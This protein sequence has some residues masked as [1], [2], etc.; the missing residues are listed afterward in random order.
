MNEPKDTS[1]GEGL[2][3]LA[4]LQTYLGA[5]LVLTPLLLWW[6]DT[7]DDVRPSISAY[8]DVGEPWAFYVPLT[9]GAMLFLVNGLIKK[10]HA[11][12]TGLGLALFGVILFDHKSLELPHE[13][14]AFTFFGGNFVV[15]WF[16]STNKSVP[17]KILLGAAIVAALVLWWQVSLFWAEWLSLVIVA[18]HFV[19]ASSKLPYRAL[20]RGERPKLKPPTAKA[21][22]GGGSGA[23]AAER[24]RV[25]PDEAQ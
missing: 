6:V 14:C 12:N 23:A 25:D 21:A 16:F 15:M 3:R 7:G 20:D 10:E 9:A 4:Q 8:Y 2:S 24:Q 19:L 1:A 18:T 17:L 11:Y 13:I 22:G 5:L